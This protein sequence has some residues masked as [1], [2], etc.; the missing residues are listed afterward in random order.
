MMRTWNGLNLYLFRNGAIY[1][2]LTCALAGLNAQPN[3]FAEESQIAEC[4]QGL[5]SESFQK[6]VN[7][8]RQLAAIA[9]D[10]LSEIEKLATTGDAETAER[11]VEVLESVF[12][13]NANDVGE[14]AEQILQR[15]SR[16]GG[17]AST[18]ADRVLQNNAMLRESRARAA[19]EKL[20]AQFVYYKPSAHI[21]GQA[22]FGF[23]AATLPDIGVGF[24]PPAVLHAVYLHEDWSGTQEDLWHLT[25]LSNHQDLAIF[26]I[27][28]NSVDI[29]DLYLLERFLTGLSIQERGACL[30]ISSQPFANGCV[31]GNVVEGGAADRGGLLTND[32]ILKLDETNIRNF[33]HLVQ[34]LQDYKIGDEVAFTVFR[35]VRQLEIKV[36]LGSWRDV[37][38]NS[39]MAAQTPPPFAGPFGLLETSED[40]T[41]PEA[42][43]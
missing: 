30:G 2:A 17:T 35:D 40:Q 16:A 9:P 27:K 7:A 5:E 3:L 31:V 19:L 13:R 34:A 6:R 37:A 15:L 12:L 11:L 33:P 25:R 24:G 21:N 1:L 26:S 32:L 41:T 39:P 29:N 4:L 14:L 22:L 42:K 8:Q 28:G 20:G 18:S 38:H 43:K 36:K 23:Q 10:H